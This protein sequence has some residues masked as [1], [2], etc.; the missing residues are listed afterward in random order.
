MDFTDI[1]GAI[2]TVGPYGILILIIVYLMKLLISADARHSS[3]LK[4][5]NEAHDEEIKELREDIAQLRADVDR[6]TKTVEDERQLRFVAEEEAHK[7]R[8]RIVRDGHY[9]HT[10]KQD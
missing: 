1:L 6:L 9:E 3:E 2:P 8:L 4:R 5:V 10:D 7:L